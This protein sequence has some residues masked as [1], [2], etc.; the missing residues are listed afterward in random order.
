MTIK[1]ET[2]LERRL[3]GSSAT[4]F[5][6]E[7]FGNS[8]Q[9]P[10]ANILLEI[11]HEGL[12]DILAHPDVYVMIL[13]AV[14]QA[15]FLSR[16]ENSPHPLRFW[17][18][19]IAPAIYTLVEAPMEGFA[20]FFNSPN[21][22]AFWSFAIL[23]GLLQA[24]KS[25]Y[26]G[27]LR[28]IALVLENIVRAAI[29]FVMYIVSEFFWNPSDV[30]T[31]QAFWEDRTHQFLSLLTLM[32]G[33]SAG[34][35]AITAQRYLGLLRDTSAQLK[36]YSEWLFGRQL[37]DKVMADPRALTLTRQ[38]RAVLF[39]DIRAFTHWA[40][41][42]RPEEVVDLLNAYYQAAEGAIAPLQVIKYKPSADEVLA[43]FATA[44]Q[45]VQAALA[46]RLR[47]HALLEPHGLGA[48][49]GVHHGPL[50]EGL[51]GSMGVRFYDV[52]GDTVNTAKRIEGAAGPGE[53]LISEPVCQALGPSC[54][55]GPRREITVKGKEA[56]LAVYPLV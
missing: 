36:T 6:L 21:H 12:L 24:I 52:I 22:I 39:M 15:L 27:L 20:D 32:L 54:Q 53:V 46:L 11:L 38:Q 37:L 16:R 42:R 34:L 30:A 29:L 28:G 13:A 26:P 3:A 40:E 8:A 47:I 4:R 50:V 35:L 23:V 25:A 56:P 31:P 49:I 14:V 1:V 41:V 33:L 43:V 19:L 45:A 55:V 2:E 10:I 9:F 44:E 51:L 48:G 5:W 7:L 18:N 17:G